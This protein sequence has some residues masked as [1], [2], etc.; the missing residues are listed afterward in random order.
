MGRIKLFGRNIPPSGLSD[1]SNVLCL[2]RRQDRKADVMSSQH[3]QRGKIN[4]RLWQPHALGAPSKVVDKVSYAPQHLG[5][6]IASIA[7]RQ[8][9]VAICLRNRV[10]VSLMAF[11]A[12]S[13]RLDD[14]LEQLGLMSRKPRAQRGSNVETYRG[15][16]IVNRGDAIAVS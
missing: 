3:L 11:L 5:L 6:F 14:L 7:E 8:N 2:V 12:E 1:R 15:V 4:R 9:G 16:I 10:A 13:I